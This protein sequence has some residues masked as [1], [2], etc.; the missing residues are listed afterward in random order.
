M[1]AKN[2]FPK[3]L[4]LPSS[5]RKAVLGRKL[6][7]KDAMAA[8]RIVGKDRVD[9]P[10]AM[11]LASIAPVLELDGKA[12]VFEDLVELDI[13]DVNALSEAVSEKN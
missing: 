5:G 7:A 10:M 13:E 1:E 3:E 9:D 11:L 12:V 2:G 8:R 4:M 6:K